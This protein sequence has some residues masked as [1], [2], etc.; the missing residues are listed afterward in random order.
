M[1]CPA[2]VIVTGAILFGFRPSKHATSNVQQKS[3]IPSV[4]T[5]ISRSPM[6]AAPMGQLAWL[7]GSVLALASPIPRHG[8]P[9]KRRA[10]ALQRNESVISCQTYVSYEL[11][12]Q[13]HARRG[14]VGAIHKNEAERFVEVS[15][16]AE[17]ILYVHVFDLLLLFTVVVVERHGLLWESEDGVAWESRCERSSAVS[18]SKP[19]T[20]L[21][22]PPRPLGVEIPFPWRPLYRA[23]WGQGSR[24][25]ALSGSSQEQ[26]PAKP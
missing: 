5:T 4:I 17:G 19:D 25:N 22:Q 16:V 21:S 6:S 14:S 11:I 8:R 10:C 7:P 9:S 24:D 18:F 23:P 12:L 13:R 2:P 3:G 15:G 20:A 26:Q 1:A